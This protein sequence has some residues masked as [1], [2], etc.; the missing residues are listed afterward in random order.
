MELEKIVVSDTVK[1]L[2]E[3]LQNRE[4]IQVE[5]LNI[6]NA[7]VKELIASN[8]EKNG[9]FDK[10]K[11]EKEIL[12]IEFNSKN[13]TLKRMEEAHENA[14]RV[15]KTKMKSEKEGLEKSIRQSNEMNTKLNESFAVAEKALLA[16][17]QINS[18]L[19][20]KNKKQKDK[21]SH[22]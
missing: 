2:E 19:E 21:I 16:Q 20:A 17:N 1:E 9:Q 22:S 4:R 3:K 11:E 12:A 18:E 14:I 5:T 7:K 10:L 6:A 13:N 8:E 15:L